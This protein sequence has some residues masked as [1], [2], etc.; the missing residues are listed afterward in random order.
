MKKKLA[1]LIG[2]EFREFELAH[3]SWP[4]L[5]IEHDFFMSTWDT[6]HEQ[7]TK[8]GIDLHEVV[9]T[10]R[11]LKYIPHAKINI[12]PDTMQVNNNIKHLYHQKK[13]FEMADKTG[14][15]Y[16]TA[17]LIRPDLNI[18]EKNNFNSF[19]NNINDS[20]IYGISGIVIKSPPE[21]IYVNEH[22]LIGKYNLLK[23]IILS[24]PEF[25]IS[26]FYIHYHIAKHFVNNDIYIES[27]FDIIQTFVMRSSHRGKTHLSIAEQLQIESDWMSAKH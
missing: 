11:I 19:I 8:L 18:I 2:G 20:S 27:L 16:D 23:K 21:F 3:R 25:D 1:I 7:N 22:I 14:V 6:S 15:E 9:T 5:T 10:D 24:L 12:E 17:I 4:F 13:V 26:K